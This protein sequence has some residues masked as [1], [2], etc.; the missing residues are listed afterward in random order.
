MSLLVLVFFRYL[1][2]IKLQLAI[3]KQQQQWGGGQTTL[4]IRT[5]VAICC[6]TTT[7]LL[8]ALLFWSSP[9][10]RT[11]AFSDWFI[12]KSST[13]LVAEEEYHGNNSNNTA[14]TP[15]I[16]VDINATDVETASSNITTTVLSTGDDDLHL[17]A[18]YPKD[19]L[20]DF[21]DD[22]CGEQYGGAYLRKFR[23]SATDMCAAAAAASDDG[24]SSRPSFTC[25]THNA[26]TYWRDR[27]EDTF[28]VGT[29]VVLDPESGAHVDCAL[30]NLTE[31]KQLMKPHA[32]ALDRIADNW[33]WTG[34]RYLLDRFMHF[35][36]NGTES[37]SVQL[38]DDAVH[39]PER[40]VL[41]VKREGGNVI[42]NVWHVF[43]QMMS[44]W[45]SLDVMRATI[46]PATG[47]PFYTDEDVKNTQV[48][49]LDQDKE[50]HLYELW[51]MFGD[52][53]T[54][55]R[56]DSPPLKST[57][58]VLPLA[59]GKNPIWQSRLELPNCNS[60]ILLQAF[61]NRILNF[62]HIPL[63]PPPPRPQNPST[64]TTKA[65]LNLVFVDRKN[66]RL[67]TNQSH[68]LTSLHSHLTT[69]H[70]HV[71]LEIID[72]A[73]YPSFPSQ[74]LKLRSTDILLG[75]H[76]AGLTHTLF[77]P[78]KSTVV[79]IQP[80]GLRYFGFAALAKFLGHRYLQVYGEEREYEGMTHN[81][82]ADD[83]FLDEGEF[84]RL[85]DRAVEGW[86]G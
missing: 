62:Y 26:W 51:N 32:Q 86:G 28:C 80:P 75:V 84:L 22:A 13:L 52:L 64:T 85:V 81:W 39:V 42:N 58:V 48:M 33:Y 53:P 27:Q 29:Q 14:S 17:S 43:M 4:S 78:P 35:R 65:P 49:I 7:A 12:G 59:G 40:T 15:G 31:E 11:Q 2:V 45:L 76:G 21:D 25:F 56:A 72:F 47:Q 19:I 6:T 74:I 69:T 50:G 60:S 71:H 10:G 30:R 44:L 67:L 24:F 73:S 3:M 5:L 68:L 37:I 46:N 57:R 79:E 8:V 41:L 36:S 54:I 1:I 66:Y 34:T 16:V 70:P 23:E 9:P 63:S 61:V 20:L 82:Q 18:A 38:A 83:V 55:R 77:L